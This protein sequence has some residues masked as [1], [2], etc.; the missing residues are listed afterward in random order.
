MKRLFF[1]LPLIAVIAIGCG[2]K[3]KKDGDKEKK[4]DKAAS[5]TPTAQQVMREEQSQ[6]LAAIH[7]AHMLPMQL[8]MALHTYQMNVDRNQSAGP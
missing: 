6:I 2:D 3:S 1:V 7:E 5:P 8:G 4:D